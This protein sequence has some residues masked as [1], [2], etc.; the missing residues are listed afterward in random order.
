M[1]PGAQRGEG[2][3]FREDSDQQCAIGVALLSDGREIAQIAEEIRR[4]NDNAGRVLVDLRKDI[5]ACRD[6]GGMDTTSSLAMCDIVRT[7]SA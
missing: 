4:L 3:G 1:E 7:T 5:F 6:I 2:H